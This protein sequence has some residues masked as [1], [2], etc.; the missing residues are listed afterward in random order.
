MLELIINICYNI[1]IMY[2]KELHI[3]EKA[4]LKLTYYRKLAGMTQTEVALRLGVT[5]NTISNYEKG[6]TMPSM[7]TVVKLAHILGTTT[8]LLLDFRLPPS[9]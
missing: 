8:D 6:H 7:D 2:Q 5:T 3:V 4:A 1:V 9:N